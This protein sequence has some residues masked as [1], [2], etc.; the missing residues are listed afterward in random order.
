MHYPRYESE[1]GTAAHMSLLT[2]P[3]AWTRRR[4]SLARLTLFILPLKEGT[5]EVVA[6]QVSV[7]RR[8]GTTIGAAAGLITGAPGSRVQF[9]ALRGMCVNL[10]CRLLYVVR[11]G[12]A[13]E[14]GTFSVVGSKA[15]TS[16]GAS[17]G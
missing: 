10:R 4:R 16:R 5:V 17:F 12:S 14:A 7:V 3:G 9:R 6:E 2:G 15:V 11:A 13:T 8:P 1:T